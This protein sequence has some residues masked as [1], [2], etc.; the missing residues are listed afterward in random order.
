MSDGRPS[1]FLAGFI[2]GVGCS[3]L[4]LLFLLLALALVLVKYYSDSG[5]RKEPAHQKVRQ[6]SDK[7]V[8]GK[9]TGTS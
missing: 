1:T 4:L 7:S 6:K 9:Y 2:T 5:K 8:K 3:A